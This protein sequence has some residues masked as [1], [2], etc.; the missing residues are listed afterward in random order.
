EGCEG[1]AHWLMFLFE[2]K[3]RLKELPPRHREGK[4]QFFP[5]RALAGLK[6]PETDREQIWPLFWQHRGGFF[7]AHCRARLDGENEWTIEESRIVAPPVNS[8]EANAD[9]APPFPQHSIINPQLGF[10]A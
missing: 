1:Q 6:L 3:R 4:F 9:V 5:A 2:I 10:N 7:A 8:D